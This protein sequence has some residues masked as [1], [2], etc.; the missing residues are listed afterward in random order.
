[1][2]PTIISPPKDPAEEYGLKLDLPL[3][4]GDTIVAESI[5]FLVE[6][7]A[8]GTDTHITEGEFF[9]GAPDV[10]TTDG[11]PGVKRMLLAGAGVHGC[12]YK[13]RAEA[14]TADGEHLVNVGILPVRTR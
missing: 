1:M 4:P 2:I 3:L 12:D 5:S 13:I 14:D 10:D 11:I 7:V 8:F 6:G 9:D